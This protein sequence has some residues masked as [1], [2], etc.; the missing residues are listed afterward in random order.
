MITKEVNSQIEKL[1]RLID[2]LK[3]NGVGLIINGDGNITGFRPVEKPFKFSLDGYCYTKP[4][5]F[6]VS[7]ELSYGEYLK[8]VL[9]IETRGIRPELLEVKGRVVSDAKGKYHFYKKEVFEKNFVLATE[10]SE[11]K[12]EE[13]EMSPYERARIMRNEI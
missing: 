10:T 4:N 7:N 11:R 5:K 9:E 12:K 2:D 8:Y 1:K 13:R 6:G 3:E